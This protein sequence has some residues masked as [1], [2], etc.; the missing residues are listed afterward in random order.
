MVACKSVCYKQTMT[1]ATRSRRI[2]CPFLI[3][4]NDSITFSISLTYARSLSAKTIKLLIVSFSAA[5]RNTSRKYAVPQV[6][7]TRTS[8]SMTIHRT[9]VQ[10]IV[11]LQQTVFY[12]LHAPQMPSSNRKTQ[13]VKFVSSSTITLP[14]SR[15]ASNRQSMHSTPRKNPQKTP[16]QALPPLK[17]LVLNVRSMIEL[18]LSGFF[19]A[20][21]YGGER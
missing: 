17:S 21:F 5:G 2:I 9:E 20:F 12:L 4:S 16:I 13:F 15:R 6:R 11:L 14:Q 10:Q 19:R 7:A 8:I 18:S 1:H 3:F